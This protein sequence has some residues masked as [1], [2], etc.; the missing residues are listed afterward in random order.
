MIS[1]GNNCHPSVWHKQETGRGRETSSEGRTSSIFLPLLVSECLKS[2]TG[3]S[4]SGSQCL[5]PCFYCKNTTYCWRCGLQ[6]CQT[7]TVLVNVSRNGISLGFHCRTMIRVLGVC[8]LNWACWFSALA[9]AQVQWPC[10]C[11]HDVFAFH[12]SES[13]QFP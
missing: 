8:M 4:V 13:A 6:R 9:R 2:V 11:K 7:H 3:S 12:L 1:S 10:A 5:S